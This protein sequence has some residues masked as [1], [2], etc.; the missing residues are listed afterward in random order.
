VEFG[1]HMSSH[2]VICCSQKNIIVWD[3]ISLL[4]T[5]TVPCEVDSLTMDPL[6]NT[7]AVFSSENHVFFFRPERSEPV[8]IHK[9]I[10]RSA[11]ASAVFVPNPQQG[12]LNPLK[13]S[14][15]FINSS[16]ELCVF[17]PRNQ[18][19]DEDET[20]VQKNINEHSTLT[21]FMEL[22]PER[23]VT[24]VSEK[25]DQELVKRP[26]YIGQAGSHIIREIVD[27][28]P[29]TMPSV[30][31]FCDQLLSSVSV[32]RDT[33][34]DI[35]EM[36][37]YLTNSFKRKIESAQQSNDIDSTDDE[38]DGEDEGKHIPETLQPKIVEEE[39][40]THLKSE[41]KENFNLDEISSGN[42][43]WIENI[44]SS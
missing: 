25:K 9:N 7:A 26:F 5:W 37:K 32:P 27:A 20:K 23:R 31:F 22:I 2:L 28:S 12:E 24:E 42:V 6:T 36:E 43:E 38:S 10:S 18:W 44:F 14:L 34:S 4:L 17:L 40:E 11:V 33:G 30:T 8:A 35:L 29:H 16:Q 39:S 3:V 19:N 41:V 13:S 21:P 15:V 1:C